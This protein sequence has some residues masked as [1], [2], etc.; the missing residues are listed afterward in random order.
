MN[1]A[2]DLLAQSNIKRESEEYL[3]SLHLADKALLAFQE[4]GNVSR[5]AECYAARSIT[6]K[7]LHRKTKDRSFLILSKMAVLA[8]VEIARLANNK[9]ALAIPLFV[10]GKA[11]AEAGEHKKAV[12][13]YKEAVGN[14]INNPPDSHNRPAVLADIK[15]HLSV[16]EYK[17]GDKTAIARLKQALVDLEKADEDSYSKNV[18]VSGAYMRLAEILSDDNPSESQEHL[19]KAKE[20]IDSDDRLTIRLKQWTELS[21]SLK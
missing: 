15:I 5:Q 20:V 8:A 13:S 3:E 4:N 17:A 21:Q 10:L 2:E 11:R 9:K 12:E 19:A 18:W 6:F 7:L 14:M 16:S 1:K